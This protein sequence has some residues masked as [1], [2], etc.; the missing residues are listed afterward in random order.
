M[1]ARGSGRM[2]E[3]IE[4]L[5]RFAHTLADSAR[6]IALQYFRQPLHVETKQDLSP[7]TLADRAI[8]AEL[9][10]MIAE[11]YPNDGVF[12][13]EEAA[14]GIDR[15][16]VWVL[17]PIDGTKSFVTG[18]PLFGTLIALLEDGAPI[19]GVI[20][21]S[22]MEERW[23]GITGSITTLNGA[24][25]HTSGCSSLSEARLFTTAPEMFNGEDAVHYQAVA[26]RVKL[27][28]YGGDCYAYGLL[29]SGHIDVVIEASLKPYDYLPCVSV[30]E[31][32]G[33]VITDWS[34][35]ALSLNSDGRVIV[36]ATPELHADMLSLL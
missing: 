29:A 11:T 15:R 36:A 4:T 30:I 1:N 5:S 21:A 6:R 16:R 31:A 2:T 23:I 10:R 25:C 27:R 8:E 24:E 14:I 18:M 28:R 26:S 9:R 12:G 32:A 20:E 34:G 17:D 19:L 33:G 22:A 7:V 35:K 3:D 13:E